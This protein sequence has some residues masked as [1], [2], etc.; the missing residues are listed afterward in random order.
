MMSLSFTSPIQGDL[1]PLRVELY[2]DDEGAPTGLA[3]GLSPK[4]EPARCWDSRA[5]FLPWEAVLPLLR[6]LEILSATIAHLQAPN[7]HGRVPGEE[8][9]V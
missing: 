8:V 4:G 6:G 1:L 2:F 3:L 7:S 5:Q 9:E